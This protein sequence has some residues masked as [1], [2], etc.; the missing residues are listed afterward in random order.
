VHFEGYSLKL[1]ML[2]YVCYKFEGKFEGAKN[3]LAVLMPVL[4][5][6]S[7]SISIL[8]LAWLFF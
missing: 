5:L 8:E 2:Y 7:N 1:S 4:H 3:G 6:A